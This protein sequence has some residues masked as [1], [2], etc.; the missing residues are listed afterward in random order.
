MYDRTGTTIATG[1]GTGAGYE[2][3]EGFYD[4]RLL[5]DMG[6]E[7]VLAEDS[8]AGHLHRMNGEV[9]EHRR[10]MQDLRGVGES[11]EKYGFV[12]IEDDEIDVPS[13]M[14]N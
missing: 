12:E 7:S 13:F 11:E 3:E 14:W 2:T 6:T 1:T 4:T 10:S 9:E 8:G 5:Y